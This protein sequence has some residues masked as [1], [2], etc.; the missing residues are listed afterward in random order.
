MLQ[1]C[2]PMKNIKTLL[3]GLLAACALCACDDEEKEGEMTGPVK[4]AL[5]TDSVRLLEPTPQLLNI[6]FEGS[7]AW[8]VVDADS[9]GSWCAVYPPAGDAS[10]RRVVS[11]QLPKNDTYVD[12]SVT[13]TIRS[14][15]EEIATRVVQPALYYVKMEFDIL[16][17]GSYAGQKI[18]INGDDWSWKIGLTCKGE[19]SIADKAE[20]IMIRGEENSS[21][22][23][24]ER[25]T[26]NF[27]LHVYAKP[28]PTGLDRDATFTVKSKTTEAK[29]TVFQ[30]G[31]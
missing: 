13:I 23:E 8:E 14:G 2:K 26:G 4:L 16:P 15:G 21:A 28:N 1:N 5:L 18:G 19:W 12:R 6:R 22:P 3:W 20:W 27:K 24:L 30:A 11:L 10:S 17:G 29:V 31:R 25:G 7:E 9:L